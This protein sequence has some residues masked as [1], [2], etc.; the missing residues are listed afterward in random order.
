[1]QFYYIMIYNNFELILPDLFVNLVKLC[2]IFYVTLC[3]IL[4]LTSKVIW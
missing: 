2:N 4:F 3:L 1:M